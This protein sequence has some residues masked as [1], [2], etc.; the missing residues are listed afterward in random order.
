MLY[1]L[2]LYIFCSGTSDLRTFQ[3]LTLT[4]A[5]SSGYTPDFSFP[6]TP[7]HETPTNSTP[8]NSEQ[9]QSSVVVSAPK[10]QAKFPLVDALLNLC[11]SAVSSWVVQYYSAI[12]DPY[13]VSYC[14][15]V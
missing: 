14:M 5:V 2:L 10:S 13:T 7:T 9:Q 3:P 6:P 8:D 1:I 4:G 15:V 12:C 11:H